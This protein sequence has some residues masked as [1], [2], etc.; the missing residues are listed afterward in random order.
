MMSDYKYKYYI[1]KKK[2]LQEKQRRFNMLGGV[3]KKVLIIE[4]T[5]YVLY[6]LRDALDKIYDCE[7]DLA[8]TPSKVKELL[9]NNVYDLIITDTIIPRDDNVEMLNIGKRSS[10]INIYDHNRNTPLII[11]DAPIYETPE[12]NT[13]Y[14]SRMKYRELAYSQARNSIDE[15]CKESIFGESNEY[16]R[17]FPDCVDFYIKYNIIIEIVNTNN[18]LTKKY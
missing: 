6:S 15:I 14:G 18:L 2:Y 10:I 13:Y 17:S 7:I 16:Y 8:N 12:I 3:R 4:D 1:M 5:D 11:L 9:S